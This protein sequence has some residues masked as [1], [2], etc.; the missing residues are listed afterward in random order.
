MN[1]F[2]NVQGE[3]LF[4]AKGG[5]G[6]YLEYIFR[7]AAKTLYNVDVTEIKYTQRLGVSE[8]QLEVRSSTFLHSLM[9]SSFSFFV[10]LFNPNGI[11]LI[12]TQLTGGRKE[13][14][15]FCTNVWT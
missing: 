11:L 7:Y 10:L 5:S 6:G 1:R 15:T 2:T 9:A 4:G 8:V 12:L 3:T 14:I 13:S